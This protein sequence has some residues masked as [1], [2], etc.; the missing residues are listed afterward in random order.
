MQGLPAKEIPLSRAMREIQGIQ[1]KAGRGCGSKTKVECFHAGTMQES[2]TLAME[3]DEALM[4]D[5]EKV[6]KALELCIEKHQCCMESPEQHCPYEHWL[7]EYE[8][9]FYECTSMLAKDAL[10][11]LKEY[12]RYKKYED[13]RVI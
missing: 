8:D 4:A 2:R 3:G 1:E 9:S 12:Q 13:D 6:I 5:R 7:G 10:A 11:L